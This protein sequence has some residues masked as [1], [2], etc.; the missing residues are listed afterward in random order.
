MLAV[1]A[2]VLGTARGVLAALAV[3]ALVEGIPQRVEVV[4]QI[5]VVA[6]GLADIVVQTRLAVLAVLA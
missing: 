1:V 3:V 6:L 4:L 2:L 5:Q